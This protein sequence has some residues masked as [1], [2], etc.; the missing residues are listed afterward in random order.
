MAMRWFVRIFVVLFLIAAAWFANVHYG[1]LPRPTPEQRDALA[2][3]RAP[4]PPLGQRD[5]F[6]ALWFIGRDVPFADVDALMREELAAWRSSPAA[7][8]FSGPD[9]G[10][11]AT[12]FPALN[13]P[14]IDSEFCRIRA[15]DCLNI[16]R[17]DPDHFRAA[18]QPFERHRLRVLELRRY[19]HVADPFPPVQLIPFPDMG[20]L[21]GS[22]LTHAALLAADGRRAEALAETCE[23]AAIWRRLRG[24]ADTLLFDMLA[25]AYASAAAR[26]AAQVVADSPE[27]EWS[28][29]CQRAFAPL[30]N[31][32]IEVCAEMRYEFGFLDSAF[33]E[34]WEAGPWTRFANSSHVLARSAPRYAALCEAPAPE[35]RRIESEVAVDCDNGEWILDPFGCSILA[36]EISSLIDYRDRV[37]DLDG[38]FAT[39]RTAIWLRDESISPASAFALRPA[40]VRTAEHQVEIDVEGGTLTMLPLAAGRDPWVIPFA[41]PD[42]GPSRR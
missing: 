29:E 42:Q 39:L 26:L 9:K 2:L 12:R 3:L 40:E 13:V 35:N 19:D 38:Q 21:Y 11:V 33:R 34:P 28:D 18:L 24:N 5:G 16:V 30:A 23:Y 20:E 15:E 25:T 1:W 36:Q 4:Q 37:I 6:A 31:E 27:V 17:R 32:E 7:E 22:A 10:P 14:E 41:R 8:R